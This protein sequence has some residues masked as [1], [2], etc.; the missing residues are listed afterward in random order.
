MAGIPFIAVGQFESYRYLQELGFLFDYG[1]ID[2]SW[3][4]DAG[5]LTRMRSFLQLIQTLAHYSIQDLD[6]M[7]R[8]ST[9]HIIDPGVHQ[10]IAEYFCQT[11][12]DSL[13][14]S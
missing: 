5:N 9:L 1:D 10:H 12:I 3:D 8:D 7:T 4:Q 2:L 14:N 6:L 11:V 13:S